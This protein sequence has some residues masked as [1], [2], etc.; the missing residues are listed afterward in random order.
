MGHNVTFPVPF[1]SELL[2]PRPKAWILSA[3]RKL[4]GST[5]GDLYL[6]WFDREVA[7]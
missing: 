2:C 7:F 6:Y 1:V 5:N 3:S 4:P